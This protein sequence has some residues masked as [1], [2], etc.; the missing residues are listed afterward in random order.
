MHSVEKKIYLGL[1]VCFLVSIIGVS[2]AYFTGGVKVTG[3]GGSTSVDTAKLI[4][5][6]YDAGDRTLSLQDAIPGM[7]TSKSFS[8][9][10]TPTE[11][12]DTATYSIQF[13]IDSNSFVKCSDSNYNANTNACI[14]NAE[15]LVYTLKDKS[16]TVLATG[17]LL[18]KTGTLEILKLTKTVSAS[19]TFD[20]TLEVSYKNLNADQNHNMNKALAGNVVVAFSS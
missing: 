15:E 14:K 10:V 13:V 2:F 17:D 4:Q 5:V 20:Y 6:K 8:V 11:D 16:G 12:Q 9:N 18:E 3:N 1:L 7:S 19:T